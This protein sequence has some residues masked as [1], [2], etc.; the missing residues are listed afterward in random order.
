M[1]PDLIYQNYYLDV[2]RVGKTV[3]FPDI[4]T[5]RP[6]SA[7][8]FLKC[9]SLIILSPPMQI[10]YRFI[11]NQ[12]YLTIEGYRP[13]YRGRGIG[14]ERGRVLVSRRINLK[15]VKGNS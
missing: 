11:E 13:E 10:G 12:R 7:V 6:P 8:K 9:L 1:I 2:S 5:V 3:Q 14:A 15:T 4:F